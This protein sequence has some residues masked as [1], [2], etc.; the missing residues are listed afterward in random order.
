M[1]KKNFLVSI[2]YLSVVSFLLAACNSS[3]ENATGNTNEKLTEKAEYQEL[4]NSQH[5]ITLAT[6]KDQYLTTEKELKV[7]IQ[8]DSNSEFFY[9]RQFSIEKKI[10]DIWYTVPFNNNLFEDIGII[11]RPKE[12]TQETISLERLK[13]KLS[14]GEYRLSKSFEFKSDITEEKQFTLVAPFKV[15]TP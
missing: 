15:N 8:N 5:G 4:P 3:V 12:S 2:L 7:T 14:Q 11:L 9:G 1:L 10:D 13:D 6:E